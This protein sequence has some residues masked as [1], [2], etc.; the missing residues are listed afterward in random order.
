LRYEELQARKH[1]M[2]TEEESKP[3]NETKTFY[4]HP[5]KKMFS[6][7]LGRAERRRPRGNFVSRF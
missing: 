2:I 3:S 7:I 6:A 1:S 5:N 4:E